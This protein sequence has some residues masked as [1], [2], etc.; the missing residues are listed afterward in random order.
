MTTT[1]ETI[2]LIVAL[3]IAVTTTTFST[4]VDTQATVCLSTD[5]PNGG[6]V[7]PPQY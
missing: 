2:A 4:S 3:G 6:S 7:P 5:P 1:L